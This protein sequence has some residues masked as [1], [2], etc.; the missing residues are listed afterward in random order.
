M[1]ARSKYRTEQAVGG[2]HSRT[3]RS[4]VGS[5]FERCEVRLEWATGGVTRS[6]VLEAT[7]HSTDA[8]LGEGGTRVDRHVDRTGQRIGFV[9]RMHRFRGETL[10]A[11]VVGLAALLTHG[12]QPNGAG[13]GAGIRTQESELR[14][15][16]RS[17]RVMT[18]TGLPSSTTMSASVSP[19]ASWQ[20]RPARRNR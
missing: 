19:S 15:P 10:P 14:K 16:R 13:A 8:V 2:R 9:T 3:E 1:I 4:A 5:G 6:R 18:P 20:P 17:W 7:A 12:P 11:D